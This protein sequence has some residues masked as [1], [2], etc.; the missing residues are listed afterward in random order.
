MAQPEPP[1]EPWFSDDPADSA[2]NPDPSPAHGEPRG[3]AE[4]PQ[5]G[6]W[7][8]EESVEADACPEEQPCEPS[9]LD[10]APLSTPALDSDSWLFQDS[11]EGTGEPIPPLAQDEGVLV[12]ETTG[13]GDSWESDVPEP[14]CVQEPTSRLVP[15]EPQTAVPTG[16]EVHVASETT[17][18]EPGFETD[19]W[20]NYFDGETSETV[21]GGPDPA[22]E[23]V[24]APA[25]SGSWSHSKPSMPT[26]PMGLVRMVSGA[27]ILGVISMV[28]VQ[29]GSTSGETA[30]SVGV[31]PLAP[32]HSIETG[33][34]L[35]GP[36]IP[37]VPAQTE[38][39]VLYPIRRE[40][41]PVP[42]AGSSV[43][44]RRA[45]R[46]PSPAPRAGKGAAS[47]GS[48]EREAGEPGPVTGGF[49]Q[50]P[51]GGALGKPSG[52]RGQESVA[53]KVVA[54]GTFEEQGD[55]P[56]AI[57]QKF[58]VTEE[59]LRPSFELLT[60][61]QAIAIAIIKRLDRTLTRK[62]E[63]STDRVAQA[64]PKASIQPQ[65]TVQTLTP[66]SPA[67]VV[68]SPQHT[69]PLTLGT[70][71]AAEVWLGLMGQQ[72]SDLGALWSKGPQTLCPDE[73]PEQWLRR[74]G[75]WEVTPADQTGLPEQRLAG[76]T[77][78]PV[79]QASRLTVPRQY[80]APLVPP[81]FSMQDAAIA[82]FQ[83][84]E[85]QP[86]SWGILGSFQPR[87]VCPGETAKGKLQRLGR[88][89]QP[90]AVVL[91]KADELPI[92]SAL[93]PVPPTRASV[94]IE[95]G[96]FSHSFEF[97]AVAAVEEPDVGEI[98]T[99]GASLAD[100][101]ASIP[102]TVTP[103]AWA[104]TASEVNEQVNT[105]Q[106]AGEEPAIVAPRG[107]LARAGGEG[108]WS[109]SEPSLALLDNP[110]RLTT[111][112]VGA[113]RILMVGGEL[114]EGRLVA[115]GQNRAWV[116]TGLGTMSLDGE[117]IDRIEKLDPTQLDAQGQESRVHKYSGRP[118]V[119]VL[120][121]GGVFS[122]HLISQEGDSV[123][124]WVDE[125]FKITLHGARL[126]DQN[127][128]VHTTLR[129]QKED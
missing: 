34:L 8:F 26:V 37:P 111:P 76:F 3:S 73:S 61:D 23:D 21:A 33:V 83:D 68:A 72:P 95:P 59:V 116:E 53:P 11:P 20:L 71:D 5:E 91:A 104:L 96:P 7:L 74:L 38:H 9:G 110:T 24:L 122:G 100:G 89:D 12:E 15:E 87:A 80:S 45:F 103:F 98:W 85:A 51:R 19:S 63:I 31:D 129:R 115:V 4:Q 88:W 119:R 18:P 106:G 1:F 55:A 58:N 39:R 67:P 113:V 124:L 30:S 99:R 57:A 125:G 14:E 64:Q 84:F 70:D 44:R 128:K 90:R 48:A 25:M 78:D 94:S 105:L 108:Q 127:E 107:I 62:P 102:K 123:T 6:S 22:V 66:S 97:L 86:E 82:W 50:D 54:P 40:S 17:C 43:S 77:P 29:V 81:V 47:M 2:M 46:S 65:P 56:Q 109:G 10:S 28:A 92:P 79:S 93:S 75:R 117:R 121:P 69:G 114:F 16:E 41:S 126:A 27:L 52:P 120:A 32:S 42:A 112:R 101:F 118:R 35:D 49:S 60:P 13:A 36:D